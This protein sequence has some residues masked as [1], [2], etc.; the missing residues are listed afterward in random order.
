[1][2]LELSNQ[3]MPS[4]TRQIAGLIRPFQARPAQLQRRVREDSK[5]WQG[6]ATWKLTSLHRLTCLAST[7]KAAAFP[8]GKKQARI[9]LPA[10]I[11]SV[12]VEEVRAN[13]DAV[14]AAVSAGATGVL[15]IGSNDTGRHFSAVNI[16]FITPRHSRRMESLRMASL[17]STHSRS[18]S[19]M[20]LKANQMC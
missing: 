4:H 13:L 3:N 16:A 19:C 10:C 14:S 7:V 17:R 15:L 8:A 12:R 5:L 9:Q 2:R 11:L 1:M 6:R 18:L 20:S